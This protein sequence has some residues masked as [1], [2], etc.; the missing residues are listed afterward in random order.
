MKKL[1]IG[2]AAVATLT[3]SG[4]SAH[5]SCADP[6]IA[7]Q[8]APLKI[9]LAAMP[10]QLRPDFFPAGSPARTNRELLPRRL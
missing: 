10:A 1:L 6:R 9:E 7:S 2:T 3:L 5:A 4:L 8:Q